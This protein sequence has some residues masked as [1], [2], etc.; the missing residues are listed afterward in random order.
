MLQWGGPGNQGQQ[1]RSSEPCPRRFI[2]EREERNKAIE[3]NLY[4][5]C[6]GDRLDGTGHAKDQAVAVEDTREQMNEKK[7]SLTQAGSK[8]QNGS[9]Q[10]SE[11]VGWFQS[12]EAAQEIR[13][14][15]HSGAAEQVLTGEW[16]SQNETTDGEKD[17]YAAA[18]VTEEA[19][20]DVFR[21][22][23]GRR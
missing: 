23:S 20:E 18:T 6:P 1:N 7:M 3:L 19:D 4:L 12:G 11:N 15:L 21:K 22:S 5:E 8:Q 14:E 9:N 2:N 16:Q 10:E 17:F 13:A